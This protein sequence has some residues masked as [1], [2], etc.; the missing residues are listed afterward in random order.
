M[1][2]PKLYAETDPDVLDQFI[3]D[4][5]FAALVSA[6]GEEP[7]ATHVPM[8]LVRGSGG[9]RLIECH[10]SRANTHWRAF[11]QPG[12]RALAIFSGAHTYV[13][14]TWYGHENVPTWNYLVVHASGPARLVTDPAELGEMVKRLS[15]HYEPTG[16]PPPRFDVAAMTPALYERELR[17]IVGIVI[18]V[19]RFEAAFKLSQNR[20]QADHATVIRK[21]LERGDDQ[22]VAVAKAMERQ[23]ERR[24]GGTP[25]VTG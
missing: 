14:P 6:S 17:G 4:N 1:Y 24:F 2:V 9:Q 12:K 11:E 23:H 25:G 20:N 5:G 8:E 7:V 19:D 3:R 18:E 13:S 22:S 10:V 15:L 16:S 21:L